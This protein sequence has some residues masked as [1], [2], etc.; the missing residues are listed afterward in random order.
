MVQPIDYSIDVQQ[1]FEAS[2]RGFQFGAGIQQAQQQRQAAE[3]QARVQAQMQ[4]D[5][6]AFSGIKN[7]TAADYASITTR[8]PQLSEHFKRSWEMLQPEQQ[9]NELSHATQVYAATLNGRNDVAEQLLRD[10]AAALR[11]SGDDAKA[12]HAETMAELVRLN[13]E[14]AKQT[15]GLMLSS[16][17]A[18]D[19][20]T[21]AFAKL[22]EERRAE[23]KAP[24][25]LTAA[26]AAAEK[27]KADAE[28]A[29]VAAKYADQVAMTDLQKKGWDIRKVAAD[30]EINKQ[31]AR[32]AAMNATI[33]REG[34]DLKRQ[35]LQLK[36][37]EA[38]QKL[39]DRIREK[40]STAEAGA[41]S[42][43][44]MLNTIER[45]KKNPA[46]NA[47]VGSIEGGKFYPQTLAGMLPG[48]ASADERADAMAL[49]ETLGSQAFVAQIPNIKGTGALSDAEGK[50]LQSALTNLSREQ[51]EKQ[52]RENL[53][54]AMRLLTKGR[55]NLSRST[56]VPLGKPDTPAAP[57]ARPPLSSFQR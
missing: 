18:P 56:G 46:L 39:D 21:E 16:V 22:G 7:P 37:Q 23:A 25:E 19:K 40:V 5:L 8:Y 28:T 12:K 38:R 17:M 51:S 26:E 2:V 1:P 6:R 32:I 4:Q 36:V 53:D 14:G 15:V 57:G 3:A 52:F 41:T 31:Q 48:T 35:E 45:I 44:N 24:A 43:D 9:K 20:F 49:I 54:E 29:K 11:N 13:P 50:K 27:A 42:I 47:V 33:A 55:E 10:R 30:I 34:N